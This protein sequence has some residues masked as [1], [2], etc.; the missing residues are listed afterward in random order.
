MLVVL[1]ALVCWVLGL[2]FCLCLGIGKAKE[3]KKKL[4]IMNF[5][6]FLTLF[7]SFLVFGDAKV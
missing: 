7:G 1:A 6:V 5:L 3:K 4:K 2:V